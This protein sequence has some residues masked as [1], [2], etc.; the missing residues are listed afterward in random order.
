[1]RFVRIAILLGGM[2]LGLV[3]YRGATHEDVL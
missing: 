1:M 2:L 3:M